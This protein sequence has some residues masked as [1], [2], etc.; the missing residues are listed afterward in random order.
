MAINFD[1]ATPNSLLAAFKEGI[2]KGHIV[3]WSLDKDGDFTHNT[4]QW[5]NRAWLRPSVYEGKLL[6]LTIIVPDSEKQPLTVYSIYH[7]RFIESM[8]AHCRTK[9]TVGSATAMPTNSDNITIA[10]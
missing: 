5:R 7:G 2:A 8:I 10:A 4:D 3:T 9:F 6:K 1:T